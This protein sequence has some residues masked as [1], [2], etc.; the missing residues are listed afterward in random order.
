MNATCE[1]W[2]CVDTAG[3]YGAGKD[4]DAARQSYTDD[5]GAI[6]EAEGF[7]FVKVTVT[8]PLPVVV[9]LTGDAPAQ[10]AATLSI[11]G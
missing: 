10:G 2:I 9:E 1:V 3:D 7:R 6:D 8:V 4:I 11:A 5:I